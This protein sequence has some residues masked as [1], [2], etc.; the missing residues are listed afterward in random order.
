MHHARS[1]SVRGGRRRHFPEPT[2]TPERVSDHRR[3]V[4]LRGVDFEV[5]V[6]KADLVCTTGREAP[7][8]VVVQQYPEV[9]H[10]QTP[11][12]QLKRSRKPLAPSLETS[13][14]TPTLADVS[15][16]EEREH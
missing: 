9:P 15:P 14:A 2:R 6:G 11:R 12:W 8:R 10:R 5:A 16:P 3:R 7:P 13:R 1:A 4:L